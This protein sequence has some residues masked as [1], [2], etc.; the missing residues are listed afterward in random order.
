MKGDDKT[1]FRLFALNII[2]YGIGI[3]ESLRRGTLLLLTTERVFVFER[4]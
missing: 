4:F 2:Y 1:K 3:R